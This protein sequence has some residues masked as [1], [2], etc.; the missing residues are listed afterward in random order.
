MTSCHTYQH[1]IFKSSYLLDIILKLNC[2]AKKVTP[3]TTMWLNLINTRKK[4]IHG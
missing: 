4:Y 2:G 3:T 1:G